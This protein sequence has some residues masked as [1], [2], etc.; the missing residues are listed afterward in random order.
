MSDP[1][2]NTHINPWGRQQDIGQRAHWSEP[3]LFAVYIHDGWKDSQDSRSGA[4]QLDPWFQMYLYNFETF[5]WSRHETETPGIPLTTWVDWREAAGAAP[6]P[7]QVWVVSSGEYPDW[8]FQYGFESL[9][10]GRIFG[11]G[12]Y[13]VK[14]DST[15]NPVSLWRRHTAF[16][17]HD[18]GNVWST[19][20]SY[21][22]P[23][24]D[25]H[26]RCDIDP[27]NCVELALQDHRFDW[28][29][30]RYV[31]D[32]MIMYHRTYPM[33]AHNT[34]GITGSP[35][36][37]LTEYQEIEKTLTNYELDGFTAKGNDD[38]HNTNYQTWTKIVSQN[39][40]TNAWH[41][42][43]VC[44]LGKVGDEYTDENGDT[45]NYKAMLCVCFNRHVL[46]RN[47]VDDSI[48]Y[49]G[50]V[51]RGVWRT[52]D[53]GRNWYYLGPIL[54]N[55]A[56]WN[57]SLEESTAGFVFHYHQLE[58]MGGSKILGL[59]TV[60]IGVDQWAIRSFISEDLGV[61]W[62]ASGFVPFS[63]R[64]PPYYHP[65]VGDD[66]GIPKWIWPECAPENMQ[67]IG[68][69]KRL[70]PLKHDQKKEDQ[71][72]DVEDVVIAI[73]YWTSPK[74][75]IELGWDN[76]DYIISIDGGETWN[77][78]ENDVPIRR[79]SRLN[80]GAYTNLPEGLV[81]GETQYQNSLEHQVGFTFYQL[82]S[83]FGFVPLPT[84]LV[85]TYNNGAIPSLNL[86]RSDQGEVWK[87]GASLRR[88]AINDFEVEVKYIE[89]IDPE[90]ET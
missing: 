7:D 60:S 24:H 50:N 68:K 81:Y 32:D 57:S 77:L 33:E 76:R 49:L 90:E 74:Y 55:G 46:E 21:G 84:Y 42:S 25:R 69:I 88:P 48:Y 79:E 43:K 39:Y 11:L 8:A 67:Y 10:N 82:W 51:Q 20:E 2:P 80:Y 64:I 37:G 18:D 61:S 52:M 75:D 22:S 63:N 35:M 16:V 26:H 83:N 14:Y 13:L 47:N 72:F 73:A 41:L 78:L 86:E 4:S 53:E 6:F 56:S 1:V 62:K 15:T 65:A 34:G 3:G 28:N 44:Y 19:D 87:D 71:E 29:N 58:Y 89:T 70:K 45:H 31:G 27:P 5:E 40:I 85:S 12:W 36:W 38:L 23:P 66:P 9:G 17:T 59:F 54:N 30:P